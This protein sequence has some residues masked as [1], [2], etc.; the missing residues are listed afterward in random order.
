M[1]K[2]STLIFIVKKSSGLSIENSDFN[3]RDFLNE[4][5]EKPE[6]SPS[7]GSIKKIMDFANSYEV[8]NSKS[9]GKIEVITN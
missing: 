1:K 7:A 8:L 9:T 2:M 4:S 5:E 6:F 3:F